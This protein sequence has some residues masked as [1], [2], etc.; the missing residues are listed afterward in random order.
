[1]SF[2]ALVLNT[3]YSEKYVHYGL[4]KQLNDTARIVIGSLIA[5]FGVV[6]SNMLIDNMILKFTIGFFT[7]CVLY[8]SFQYIFNKKTFLNALL[9]IKGL[10][11]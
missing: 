10:K 9:L 6:I 2:I 5:G 4:I 7:F 11:K 3:W 1:M 8:L